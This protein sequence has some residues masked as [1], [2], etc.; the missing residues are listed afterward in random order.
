MAAINSRLHALLQYEYDIHCN[1]DDIWV[2]MTASLQYI[3]QSSAEYSAINYLTCFIYA[4]PE[5]TLH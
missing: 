5:I 3:F 1:S 2:N 4:F